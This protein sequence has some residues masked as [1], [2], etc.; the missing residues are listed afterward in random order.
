MAVVDAQIV[1]GERDGDRHHR[2]C[3][4]SSSNGFMG[5]NVPGSND[6]NSRCDSSDNDMFGN[7][8]GASGYGSN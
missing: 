3:D 2:D 5:F 4:N 6:S 7:M 1:Q 8:F